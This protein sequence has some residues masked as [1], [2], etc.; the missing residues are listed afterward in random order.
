MDNFD[1]DINLWRNFIDGKESAFACIYNIYAKQMYYYGLSLN[2]N[3]DY[4][5]DAIHDVFIKIYNNKKKLP[6]VNNIKL[7]LFISLKN[8]LLSS[9]K[10]IE[11]VDLYPII[12]QIP[13]ESNI[14]DQIVDK[15]ILRQREK[16][17]EEINEMLSQRQKEA[18]Y[19]RFNQHLPYKKIAEQMNINTQSA[20]NIVQTAV[21]KIRSIFSSRKF[22]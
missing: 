12:N 7:Y 1:G 10:K 4:L 3:S 5:E 22:Y 9:V 19:Y 15:E 14:E 6:L 18:F 17:I 11:F 16:F 2:I 20:K 8:E 13:I 21:V